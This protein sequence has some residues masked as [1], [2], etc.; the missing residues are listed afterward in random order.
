MVFHSHKELTMCQTVFLSGTPTGADTK[1]L[2]NGHGL[3]ITI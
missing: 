1:V 3:T 2:Q